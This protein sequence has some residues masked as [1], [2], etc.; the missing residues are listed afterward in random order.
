M[1]RKMTLGSQV[2]AGFAVVLALMTAVSL[3]GL[4]AMGNVAGSAQVA[5]L[6]GDM[7][8]SLL[9]ARRHEK[10]YIIRMDAKYITK[11]DKSVEAVLQTAAMLSGQV[12]S[13]EEREELGA[14][15]TQTRAYKKAFHAYAG[16]LQAAAAGDAKTGSAKAQDEE[17]SAM[18]KT[19]RAAI[20]AC[21][22]MRNRKKQ[23]MADYISSAKWQNGIG[24]GA[25]ISIGLLCAWL[26]T[27][28]VTKPLRRVIDVLSSGS[29]EVANA[30]GH[31]S[32]ASQTLAE[33]AGSQ[34]ATLEET[35]ATLEQ[36]S[37]M[38]RN[39]A[40]GAQ[41]ATNSRK[42]AHEKLQEA[43]ELMQQAGSAMDKVEQAGQQTAKVV[44]AIDEIS[45][46]TNMLAL[47]AAVEA[48]RAGD[49][50]NGFAVVAEEVRNLALRAADAA[51]NTQILIQGSVQDIVEGAEL[52]ARAKDSFDIVVDHNTEV[53]R[54]VDQIAEA[55]Q[56]QALGVEQMS[57]SAS[58]MN[59]ITQHVAASAEQAAVAAE[60][61]NA[62]AVEMQQVVLTITQMINGGKSNGLQR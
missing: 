55:S 48:A 10:N 53:G 59:G 23:Q 49:A 41:D 2:F 25:G 5:D 54:L 60:Q 21:E 52:V 56:E 62:Q 3:S 44:K 40:D 31:V 8:N 45:F 22:S 58:S 42:A 19:A 57:D 39:T 16:M 12:D 4:W 33:G 30:S 61:L 34:A 36:M 28:A 14:V 6:C 43:A 38:I 7:I 29:A 20:A 32:Q 17:G 26:I 27:M 37:A 18:V 46:Q 11:V 47:N 51:R 9:E 1:I 50:G 35:S 13:D 15:D 24:M